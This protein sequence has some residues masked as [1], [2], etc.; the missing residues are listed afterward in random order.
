MSMHIVGYTGTEAIPYA[1][2]LG[3]A[4]Q[5]TNILRDVG[6]DW[7]NGRLYLPEDEAGLPSV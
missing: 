7:R 3:M 1:V 2:K 4:L 5:P 6:E